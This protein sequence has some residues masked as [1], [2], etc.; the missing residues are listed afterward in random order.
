MFYGWHTGGVNFIFLLV[1][2]IIFLVLSFSSSEITWTF[3][4]ISN[5]TAVDY[6]VTQRSI[7]FARLY[8]L[9]SGLCFFMTLGKLAI[10]AEDNTK[11]DF[12]NIWEKITK[13]KV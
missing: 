5:G 6:T 8:Q 3:V 1:S 7:V 9:L 11:I 12:S 10:F 2:L 4:T 13:G